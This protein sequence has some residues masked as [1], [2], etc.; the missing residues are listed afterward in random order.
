MTHQG[1]TELLNYGNFDITEIYG[2]QNFLSTLFRTL[3][4]LGNS[5][6]SMKIYDTIFKAF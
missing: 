5:K 6:W 1:V 3:Y 2:G 4:P